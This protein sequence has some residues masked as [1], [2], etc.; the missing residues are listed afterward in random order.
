MI[1]T[2]QTTAYPSVYTKQNGLAFK[3]YSVTYMPGSS[4]W[5]LPQHQ[6][7]NSTLWL[8]SPF[9]RRGVVESE[10]AVWQQ[11]WIK[12]HCYGAGRPPFQPL[13]QVLQVLQREHLWGSV[14]T[15]LMQLHREKK[16]V[17]LL[18]QWQVRLLCQLAVQQGIWMWCLR[19]QV[20]GVTW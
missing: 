8:V 13:A 18:Q 19:W 17:Y 4:R 6:V 10:V 7:G 1:W 16:D 20:R 9:Q 3:T 2:K 11:Q 14:H 5:T 12:E 15:A